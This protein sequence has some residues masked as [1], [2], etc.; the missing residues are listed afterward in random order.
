MR[1]FKIRKERPA[2]F[3]EGFVQSERARS[4]WLANSLLPDIEIISTRALVGE[5]VVPPETEKIVV[6]PALFH[7]FIGLLLLALAS[8]V[9]WYCFR[10]LSQ[11]VVDELSG[12]TCL[13]L[14]SVAV[15]AILYY[16]FLGKRYNYVLTIDH[17]GISFG[18]NHITWTVIA[19][20]AI[21]WKRGR[22]IRR[23]YLV[24]L[25]SDGSTEKLRLGLLD[26]SV[27]WLATVVEQFKGQ[28]LRTPM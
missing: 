12:G 15:F 24:L 19:E 20:T 13:V 7:K 26:I 10:G 6:R 14:L 16:F 1:T 22:K 3:F 4:G 11:S 18:T 23:R 25:R 8:C 5:I 9:W 21:M 17:S 28:H 2:G 27:E